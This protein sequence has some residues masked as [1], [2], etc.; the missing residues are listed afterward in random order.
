MTNSIFQSLD[1]DA[2]A[3]FIQRAERF[4]CFAA[5][6]ILTTPATGLIQ[7]AKKIGP[8]L[9]AVCLDFDERVFRMGYGDLDAVKS[10]R[11]AKIRVSSSPGLRT[12]LVVVDD[13]GFIFTPTALFLEADSRPTDAPNAMRLTREQSAAALSG[14]SEAAKVFA[15]AMAKSEDERTRLKSQVIE[16]A[17]KPVEESEVNEVGHNLEEA[18]PVRFDLERQVRVY[19][20]YFQYVEIKLTGAA[21]QRHRVAIPQKIQKLG[22]AKD[23]EGRLKTIFDLVEEDG[24]FSSKKLHERLKKIRDDFTPSLGEPHRRVLL[25]SKKPV[26][27]ERIVKFQAKLEKFQKKVGKGLQKALDD[28]RDQ[29][30]DYYA[31]IAKQFP[32]D[33]MIGKGLEGEEG[34]RIWLKTVLDEVFPKAEK[35]IQKMQIEV[36]YK[37][38]TYDTLN[39]EDFFLSI[40]KAFP[41]INWS[42]PHQESIAVKEKANHDGQ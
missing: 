19:S 7:V 22:G 2:I 36:N 37:D 38:M 31:P 18:P 8:E 14:L 35:L 10:I 42:K 27:E 39:D 4:V 6:G 3:T 40:K 25:K 26:F 41:G 32:P 30:I 34:A 9:V 15:L 12:G 16:V 33:E 1:S 5:P 13:Q 21:I 11:E 29:I 28:S 20:A 24:I 23:L 17:S